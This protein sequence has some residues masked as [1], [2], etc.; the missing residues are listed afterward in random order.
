MLNF[1]SLPYYEIKPLH[2]FTSQGNG[3]NGL[4]PNWEK[5]ILITGPFTAPQTGMVTLHTHGTNDR[6]GNNV[7]INNHYIGEIHCWTG[8]NSTV[9]SYILGK[10]D[11]IEFS[12]LW[13]TCYFIPFD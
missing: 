7:Y 2:I 6:E 12:N 3:V 10:G 11:T 8:C 5:A 4:R 1:F 9:A 13:T